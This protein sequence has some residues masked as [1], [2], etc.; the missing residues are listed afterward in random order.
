MNKSESQVS[1]KEA[2]E[3]IHRRVHVEVDPEKYKFYP[4]KKPVDFYD[5]NEE[6][7]VGVY[8]RVSTDNI[9][10]TTSFELQQKYYEYFVKEHPSWHLVD[11]Y[12]DEGISGTSLKHRDQFMRMIAD[13]K[14]GKLNLIITKSV[15]R[16]ARNLTDFVGTVR[17]LA[18]MRNP[19]GVLFE[20]EHLFSL[21]DENQMALSFMATMAE[22][23]SHIRSRS[24][25]ASLRMRLDHG[26]L[27]TPKLLGY[28]HDSDGNLIVN[29]DEA[30]TVKLMF[31][32]YLHGYS[33]QQIADKLN[34]LQRKSYLGNIKWTSSGVVQILRNERHC[35]DVLTRKTY[36]YD[37]R[38]HLSRKNQGERPQSQYLDHHE[39]IISRDD[40]I[41]VQRKLDSARFRNMDYLPELSVVPGGLLKG[42]VSINPRWPG[43]TV[44]DYENASKSVYSE[45]ELLHLLDPQPQMQTVKVGSGDFDLRGFEVARQEFLTTNN[46][47]FVTFVDQKIKFGSACIRRLGETAFVEMLVNPLEKRFAIRLTNPSNRHGVHLAK[48]EAGRFVPREVP[49]SAFIGTIFSLFGWDRDQKYRIIGRFFSS[50]DTK[51]YIFDGN[52]SEVHMKIADFQRAAGDESSLQPVAFMCS[53]KRVRAIPSKWANH[54]GESYYSHMAF[55]ERCFGLPESQWRLSME[56]RRFDTNLEEIHVT[57]PTELEAYIAQEFAGN[58]LRE[59]REN[60]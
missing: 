26:I 19:V 29:E 48:R 45:K 3:K 40:F 38:K 12:A 16:F 36:T 49:A 25:E 23:E 39:A 2:K 21:K 34:E 59:V 28:T 14:A 58:R 15:S 18:E 33:T 13:A 5:I 8:V 54:F 56:A 60:G 11:I 1:Y 46:Q 55:Y 51:V 50:R 35:G 47:P 20:S 7:N 52:D 41:A 31:Y 57:D 43:F 4:E 37:Y 9:Q 24:M 10:Q 22:E 32:M 42:Y 44:T 27:L 6:L 53:G 17:E 30:P